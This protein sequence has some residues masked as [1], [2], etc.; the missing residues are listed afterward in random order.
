M[1]NCVTYLKCE[2]WEPHA[3]CGA[4][5]LASVFMPLAFGYNS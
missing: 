1:N 2:L 3:A 4:I 5:L